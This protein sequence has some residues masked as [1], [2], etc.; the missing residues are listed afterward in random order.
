M[1]LTQRFE[2]LLPND[3]LMKF[4]EG[5]YTER[6]PIKLSIEGLKGKREAYITGLDYSQEPLFGNVPGLTD[7][8]VEMRVVSGP[9]LVP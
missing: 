9:R 4:F 2:G 8:A 6:K 5:K 7:V 3:P 1:K